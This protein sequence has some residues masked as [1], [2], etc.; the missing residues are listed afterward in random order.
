MAR[1]IFQKLPT[2]G[3]YLPLIVLLGGV[4]QNIGKGDS[5]ASR[6]LQKSKALVSLQYQRSH[7][8]DLRMRVTGRCGLWMVDSW[9]MPSQWIFP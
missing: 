4:I 9:P 5:V 7:L 1:L 2:L 6:P 3:Q 8:S